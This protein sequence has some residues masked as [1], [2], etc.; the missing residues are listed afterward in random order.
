MNRSLSFAI[1]VVTLVL[2]ASALPKPAAAQAQKVVL[3]PQIFEVVVHKYDYKTGGVTYCNA[4]S[5]YFALEAADKY[6]ANEYM[7]FY[8]LDDKKSV[9]H[10]E[11][12]VKNL[13]VVI[14]DAV[15]VPTARLVGRNGGENVW[16]LVVTKA[17]KEAYGNCLGKIKAQ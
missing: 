7:L 4:S 13:T 12:L 14:D 9:A 10:D 2:F 11:A 8:Y 16:D 17:M 15:T 3:A 6:S 5:V 1:T